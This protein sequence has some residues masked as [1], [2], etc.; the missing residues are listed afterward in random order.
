VI[1]IPEYLWER[2]L[3]EF[4]RRK[5]AV[6]QVCYFDGVRCGEDGV[7]VALTVPNA[8]LFADHFEVSPDA[9]SQAGKHLRRYQM[10][11]LAQVHTHPG[12]WVGH[13]PWDD[14]KAYS[15]LDGAL[16]LVL[17]NHARA[18]PRLE[19]A[20]VH[21]RGV[22]GWEQLTTQAAAEVIRIV[23]SYLDFRADMKE[24]HERP[25]IQPPRKRPWWSVFALWKG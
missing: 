20:A 5:R 17:P 10:R 14:A 12:P 9:M 11:R 23:P 8:Q 1:T 3:D 18:R 15:Q 2:M 13:S 22:P 25:N 4:A 19:E 24:S 7:V 21:R 6:E 16:S